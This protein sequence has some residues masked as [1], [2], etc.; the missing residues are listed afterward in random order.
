MPAVAPSTVPFGA[1]GRGTGTSTVAR[2]DASALQAYPPAVSDIPASLPVSRSVPLNLQG[3]PKAPSS[4]L[5]DEITGEMQVDRAGSGGNR[6][7]NVVPTTGGGS[8][9]AQE[10]EGG[11]NRD[12]DGDGD[13]DVTPSTRHV[14]FSSGALREGSREQEDDQEE[15]DDDYDEEDGGM[16][17]RWDS[18]RSTGGIVMDRQG[19]LARIGTLGPADLAGV[20]IPESLVEDAGHSMGLDD[21]FV[22]LTEEKPAVPT[23]G[24]L[25]IRI[26]RTSSDG[27]GGEQGV[28]LPSTGDSAGDRE[29]KD[30]SSPRRRTRPM[31]GLPVRWAEVTWGEL[32]QYAIGWYALTVPS[33]VLLLAAGLGTLVLG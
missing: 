17:R 12:G 2:V 16:L 1:P 24:D 23:S 28:E 26:S 20:F 33:G 3:T 29:K 32:V 14:G 8:S 15:D 30:K 19:P 25:R 10:S 9:I 5:R 11:I 4:S 7:R 21:S 18:H 6:N 27:D 31:I 22:D 13:G